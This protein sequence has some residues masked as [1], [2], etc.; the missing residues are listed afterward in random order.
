MAQ[1]PKDRPAY[2]T[3]S[4]APSYYRLLVDVMAT[5]RQQKRVKKCPSKEVK[6]IYRR[7]CMCDVKEMEAFVVKLTDERELYVAV[8]PMRQK[9]WRFFKCES[10]LLSLLNYF[11]QKLLPPL[12]EPPHW[13]RTFTR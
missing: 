12:R 2:S 13:R 8:Y 7:L 10:K 11:G 9:L 6:F 5:K 3:E 1:V 4:Y